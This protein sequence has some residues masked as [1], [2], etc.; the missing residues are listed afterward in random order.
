L[1]CDLQRTNIQ[2]DLAKKDSI[3]IEDELR[4][5]QQLLQSVLDHIPAAV[6]WKD[7]NHIYRG[8]NIRAAR[9]AG[10][11]T[12]EELV[13]KDDFSTPLWAQYAELY[14]GDDRKVLDSGIPK[15]N[16]EEPLR[17]NNDPRWA[18][19]SKIPMTDS[20]GNSTGVLG[21]YEDIT[22]RKLDEA[23]LQ[24]YAR[25]LR[26]SN[27]ELKDF[28]SIASHDLQEPLRKII[29]FGEHL[30]KSSQHLDE[31]SLNY[32]NRMQ[33][34]TIRMQTLIEDLLKLTSVT[35]QS[36]SFK[37][38]DMNQV[39]RQS[40]A[41]LEIRIRETKGKV[42]FEK[43]PVIDANPIQMVQLFQNLIG[44]ALK[45]HRKDVEPVINISNKSSEDGK[46]V[47]V[48]ADN[49]LGFNEK[50]TDMIFQ[51]FHRLYGKSEFE[52]TGMGLTICKKIVERHNGT[53]IA[54]SSQDKGSVFTISLPEKQPNIDFEQ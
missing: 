8:G 28:V 49:G 42:N 24:E 10:F 41:A 7:V 22:Q 45:Y 53:I 17:D 50:Y 48:V 36:Q 15:L 9:D 37:P 21:I 33:N 18:R 30:K 13:G 29:V 40:L 23:R 25:A 20:K 11:S 5:S 14:R 52:G 43:L 19:T 46:I 35:A 1:T 47:V 31:T 38:T 2:F 3:S 26:H 51:P 6:F 34:A 39:V 32:I 12:V 4:Q 27:E 54:T 16:Y 44:N